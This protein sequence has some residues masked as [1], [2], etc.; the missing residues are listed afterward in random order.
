MKLADLNPRWIGAGGEGIF[1]RNAAG[2]LEPAPRREGVGIMFDCPCGLD[3]GCEGW[4]YVAFSNPRDGGAP[5][6]SPGQPTWARTG[7]S[8]ETLTLSPSILRV[9]GCGWHGWVR[10]GEVIAC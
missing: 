4:V 5:I 9:G 3:R 1:R 7:E 6:A 2:E 8:F 10:N